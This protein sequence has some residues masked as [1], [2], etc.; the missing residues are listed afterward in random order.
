M[1]SA[2]VYRIS[3]PRTPFQVY[4]AVPGRKP[5]R[6]HF[7][8]EEAAKAHCRDLNRKVSKEGAEG[9]YF[10]ELARSEYAAAMRILEPHGVG[11]A[12]AAKFFDAH[13]ALGSKVECVDA[14]EEFLQE[15]HDAN[16]SR[17]TIENIS[18]RVR[19]FLDTVCPV[20]LTDITRVNLREYI[21]RK[22]VKPQTR[23]NDYRAFQNWFNWCR[24]RGYLTTDLLDGLDSPVVEGRRVAVLTPEQAHALMKAAIEYEPEGRTK[25]ILA[26]NIAI[27]LYAGLRSSELQALREEDIL[28]D[29]IRVG[30]GKLRGRRAVRVVP[31]LPPL[32]AVL[33]SHPNVPLWPSNYQKL[34]KEV[35]KLADLRGIYSQDICRHSWISYRLAQIKDENQIARE[36]GNSPDVIYRH[37]WQLSTADEA[38]LY[39]QSK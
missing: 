37:Y 19:A 38:T 29:I 4:L 3:H 7:K 21:Y 36:A 6:K 17:R 26:R 32:R 11:I 23:L 39:F 9:V 13:H 35:I 24:K 27:R 14:L 25:G 2:R 34:F 5:Y 31:I 22:G 33:D 12:E 30:A 15:K 20:F 8:T 18:Y 10:G 28:P 16:R 1:A